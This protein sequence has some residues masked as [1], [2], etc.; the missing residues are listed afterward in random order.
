LGNDNISCFFTL[1]CVDYSGGFM[2]FEQMQKK[3][4]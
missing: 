4:S 2:K 1:L 3:V